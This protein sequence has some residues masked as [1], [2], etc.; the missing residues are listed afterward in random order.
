MRQIAAVD[1]SRDQRPALPPTTPVPASL[2]AVLALTPAALGATD[3]AVV[4]MR[5]A[6]GLPGAEHLDVLGCLATL[7]R[8]T[9]AVRRYT[10]DNADLYQHDPAR[11]GHH[12]GFSK[13][14]L[15]AVLLKRGIGVRYQPAAIGNMRFVDSRDDL[16]HGLLTRKLGTCTSLPVLCVAIGRRLGYPVHLAIAKGHVLCQWLNEDGSHVNFEVSSNDGDCDR[17]PDEHY[18]AWPKA[19]TADDLA[20]GRYLRPL[21]R[22]EELALFLETRGHCLADNG[23]FDEAR[24]AYAQAARVAPMWSACEAHMRDV[25]LLE[26]QCRRRAKGD[27]FETALPLLPPASNIVGLGQCP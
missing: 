6:E 2:A 18:H 13:L 3:V 8:W 16:L 20:S 10:R 4:N 21:A 23:R 17:F 14:V 5:C 25:T 27:A 12:E 22:A 7:D 26:A 9:D 1:G 19:M 15:M 24:E 11:Y